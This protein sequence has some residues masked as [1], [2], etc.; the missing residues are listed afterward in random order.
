MPE[1]MPSFLRGVWQLPESD[2]SE[3]NRLELSA[4]SSIET[5]DRASAINSYKSAVAADPKFTRAWIELAVTYLSSAAA[6]IPRSI[7]C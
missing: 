6:A 3:A 1:G 2:V 5:G 7:A 4:R